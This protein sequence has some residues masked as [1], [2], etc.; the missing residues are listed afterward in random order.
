V[1]AVS[2]DGTILINIR[3]NSKFLIEMTDEI[4][5]RGGWKPERSA[6]FADL[7]FSK[8]I[9]ALAAS[10]NYMPKLLILMAMQSNVQY[11]ATELFKAAKDTYRKELP[12]TL[13]KPFDFCDKSLSKIGFT[14]RGR[15]SRRKT[16]VAAFSKTKAAEIALAFGA[17][18]LT[19]CNKNNIALTDLLGD[20]VSP[21]EV[22]R[23]YVVA[24][25]LFLLGLGGLNTVI[26]ISIESKIIPNT[27]VNALKVL[28]DLGLVTYDSVHIDHYKDSYHGLFSAKLIDANKARELIAKLEKGDTSDLVNTALWRKI[29]TPL[30]S[31]QK[32]KS[33]LENLPEMIDRHTLMLEGLPPF[34]SLSKAY[35]VISGLR[36][37]GIYGYSDL[38]HESHSN[39]K[40]TDLGVAAL[41]QVFLPMLEV[42]ASENFAQ[43]SE[44]RREYNELGRDGMLNLLRAEE[45]N[46]IARK[47]DPKRSV[48]VSSE[49]LLAHIEEHF[50]DKPFRSKDIAGFNPK[51]TSTTRH[52][53]EYLRHAGTI[54][55]TVVTVDT[56][57]GPSE[58]PQGYYR[59]NRD[60]IK[61]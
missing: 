12:F 20:T 22:R 47:T 44:F 2:C 27:V 55:P 10:C 16:R 24:T 8:K 19:F 30:I 40:I 9:E 7:E 17:K 50:G 37:L 33:L 42:A 43:T 58:V 49:H 23:G 31:I 39:I 52:C 41:E 46:Y 3:T 18:V 54:I 14:V 32:L 21:G 59:I 57:R 15:I 53:L 61:A 35:S 28:R 1:N 48:A 56:V 4:T 6:T 45:P 11:S 5:N 29:G 36:E 13:N 60:K 38:S 34:K 26:D 51:S 25:C